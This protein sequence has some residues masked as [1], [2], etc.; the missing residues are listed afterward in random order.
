MTL[1]FLGPPCTTASLHTDHMPMR[2]VPLLGVLVSWESIP[3]T[4]GSVSILWVICLLIFNFQAQLDLML[5]AK[6]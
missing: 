2:A 3:S 5:R 1:N 6:L 4:G